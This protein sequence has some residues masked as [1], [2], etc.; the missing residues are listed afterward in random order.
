MG[1]VLD[2]LIDSGLHGLFVLGTTGEGPLLES[3]ERKAVAE[4]A[5][6]HVNGRRPVLVHAGTPD[7]RT[8]VDL[9]RHAQAIGADAVATVVPY[10]FTYTEAQLERHFRTI[11]E[12]APDIGHY[13]YE[14][15]ERVGY[16]A[17]VSLVC[18]L[19]NQVPN[20]HGVK[21]T[22]DTIGKVT[23]Y[24]AQPGIKPDV[25]TGNNS[26]VFSALSLGSAGAVSALSN[27][28]PE[29]ISGIY[30]RFAKGD[31]DGSRELQFILAR[32]VG[33]LA[34]TPYAGAI[35]HLLRRRG[36]PGGHTRLPQPEL[37]PAEASTLDG[38]LAGI[39]GLAEWL[40]PVER[41]TA[42]SG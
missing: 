29:L 8:A 31:E 11:A 5:V 1:V 2:F 18:R 28:A 24:L 34:G 36:L 3:T 21:D 12:A 26:T 39:D 23:Q 10:Y 15:P 22:G 33:A 40:E 16:S 35:K 25:Y 38:K 9:A 20:I 19:V 27:F 30:E 41:P 42:A 6:E 14:N 37:S 4:F 17:G 32:V 7:T 13:V